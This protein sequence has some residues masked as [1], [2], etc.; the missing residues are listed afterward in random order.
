MQNYRRRA[1]L[2]L[3]AAGAFAPFSLAFA[4]SAWP[5]KPIRIINPY[6]PGGIADLAAR[7]IQ[8]GLQN[9]LG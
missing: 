3:G 5:D 7:I 8:P 9:G 1:V 4:Q 6:A 2:A